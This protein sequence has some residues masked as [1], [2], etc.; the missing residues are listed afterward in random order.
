M[1][2]I[3]K[4]MPLIDSILMDVIKGRKF[5]ALMDGISAYVYDPT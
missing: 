3:N 1:D 5:T 4:W 2:A